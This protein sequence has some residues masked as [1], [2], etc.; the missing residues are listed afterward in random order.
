MTY[1][2]GD[3]IEALRRERDEARASISDH[4]DLHR[5]AAAELQGRATAA[6]AR[7]L[8]AESKL[9]E[10]KGAFRRVRAAIFDEVNS[11][12]IQCTVFMP[13]EGCPP[14]ETIVDFIDATLSHLETQETRHDG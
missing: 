3:E 4:I 6:E 1:T 10:A 13:A 5:K 2:S 14:H 12:A 7:A 9:A 8:L 11:L